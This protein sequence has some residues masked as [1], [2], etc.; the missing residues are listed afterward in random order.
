MPDFRN[1]LSIFTFKSRTK[2]SQADKFVATEV[3]DSRYNDAEVLA[4]Y[5]R[6]HPDGFQDNQFEIRVPTTSSSKVAC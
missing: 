2:M 4:E 5:L 1:V 3:F 6:A